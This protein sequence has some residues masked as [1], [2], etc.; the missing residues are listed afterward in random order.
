[1]RISLRIVSMEIVTYLD[2]LSVVVV[3]ILHNRTDAVCIH[4]LL[5]LF[6]L[7]LL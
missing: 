5:P 2:L 4:G 3:G 6:G 1:M 7:G